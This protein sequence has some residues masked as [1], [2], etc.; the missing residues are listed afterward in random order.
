MR[1]GA[2]II[3]KK[4][5]IYK[6]DDSYCLLAY[7]KTKDL[8]S[9]GIQDI[10]ISCFTGSHQLINVN[11]ALLL[12]SYLLRGPMGGNLAAFSEADSLKKIQQQFTGEIINWKEISKW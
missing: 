6:F 8:N 9:S 2:E 5:R 3:T 1:F 7:L 10:Y 12:Q 11:E 4:G